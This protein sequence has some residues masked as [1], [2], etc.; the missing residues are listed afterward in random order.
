[1]TSGIVAHDEHLTRQ[2]GIIEPMSC[3]SS[4]LSGRISAS[5]FLVAHSSGGVPMKP[6]VAALWA[7]VIGVLAVPALDGALIGLGVGVGL[8]L[9]AELNEQRQ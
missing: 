2:D 3:P 6:L 4:V 7:L 5:R 1:M 9:L 8:G